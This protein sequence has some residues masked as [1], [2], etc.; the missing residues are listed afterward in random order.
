M[1]CVP[2]EEGS[3]GVI[4]LKKHND[5]LLLKNLDKFFK[6]KDI[7]W[8]GLVWEKHYPNGKLP[9]HIKKGLSGGEMFLNLL[10]ASS[11]FLIVKCK[12]E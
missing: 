1:V 2:K 11:L 5:A 10:I 8:V 4:D 9:I 3:L 7:P 12:M 6:K